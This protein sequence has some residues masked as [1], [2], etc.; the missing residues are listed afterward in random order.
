MLRNGFSEGKAVGKRQNCSG[1]GKHSDLRFPGTGQAKW[2][3]ALDLCCWPLQ[4]RPECVTCIRQVHCLRLRLADGI[5]WHPFSLLN[6]CCSYIPAG[7]CRDSSRHGAA[8]FAP[9]EN[10]LAPSDS[11][12][13]LGHWA[14][15]FAYTD[16]LSEGMAMA[17]HC[18]L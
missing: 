9:I 13:C 15:S 10:S 17:T 11:L 18:T 8:C 3:K 7:T 6:F 1:S 5:A 2:G 14:N 16:S 12:L 4:S